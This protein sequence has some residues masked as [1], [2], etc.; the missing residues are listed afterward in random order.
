MAQKLLI[1]LFVI[2][3][4]IPFK[5]YS[6]HL[7]KAKSL[8]AN[9]KYEEAKEILYNKIKNCNSSCDDSTIAAYKVYLGKCYQILSKNDSALIVFEEAHQQ[10]KL[11]K[12]YNGLAFVL[13]SQAEFNRSLAQLDKAKLCLEQVKILNSKGLLSLSNQAYLFNRSAAISQESN[14]SSDK[15]RNYLN[16]SILISRKIG[17]SNNIAACYNE[18]GKMFEKDGEHKDSVVYYYKKA[19]QLWTA[20]KNTRYMIDVLANLTGYYCNLG[21]EKSWRQSLLYA[22]QALA[23]FD[24]TNWIEKKPNL[25]F[26]KVICCK[27]LGDYKCTADNMGLLHQAEIQVRESKWNETLKKIE[28]EYEVKLK[29][30]QINNEQRRTK[31]AESEAQKSKTQRNISILSLV[32]VLILAVLLMLAYRKIRSTNKQLSKSV[33]NKEILMQE[34]H[35]R[36]KN[37]LTILKSLIYLRLRSIEDP[38]VQEIL[39]ELQLRIHSM[40]MIH[41]NLYDVDD[42][43]QINFGEFLQQLITELDTALNADEDKVKIT[44]DTNSVEIEMRLA[45]YLGLIFNEFI[46]NSYKH[47]FIQG[48]DKMIRVEILTQEEYIFLTYEDNGLNKR[49]NLDLEN[50]GGFGF[51]LLNILL[52][53]LGATVNYDSSEFSKFTLK[54]KRDENV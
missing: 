39:N 25:Y 31:I 41:Q 11:L 54:F 4:I 30:E 20:Q 40:A 47:S 13:I 38:N 51:R 12:N 45:I 50:S 23:L 8:M 15:V 53:Q 49:E 29:E 22:D 26:F 19:L 18:L 43:S 17:D 36:V 46:T 35:H 2:L 52:E 48:Q 37:N 7:E 34:V 21:G 16:K 5:L 42:S 33:R 14:A 32:A 1:P 9:S 24:G 6:N 3:V 27:E 28:T 44:I 10:Y